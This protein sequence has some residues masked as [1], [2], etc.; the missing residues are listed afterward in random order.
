MAARIALLALILGAGIPPGTAAEWTVRTGE[1]IAAAI[2]QAAPG[3]TVVVERGR[4]EERLLIDKPLRL[5]G[6]G[7]PVLS[8]GNVGDT[9]RIKA[10]DVSIEGF[11]VRDSGADLTA[12]NACI[13]VE[14]GS[15]RVVVRGNDLAHCLFGLWLQGVREP[16]VQ[17]NLITGKR[18]LA[19]PLRGNG[20]QLYA[21]EFALIENNNISFTRDGVY[22]DVSH[23]AVFRGNRMH[24]LRY[25]THY[26]NSNGNL[27]ENNESFLNRGGLAMMEVRDQVVRG[28]RAWGNSDHGIMLRSIVDSLV[29]GNIVAANQRGLFIFNAEYNDIRNNLVIDN[30]VGAHVWA[31]S[32]NNLVEGNDFIANRQQ[33]RYVATRDERWGVERGNFWSNYAGW[34]RDGDG[35]GDVPYEASD[36]VDRL[37]WRHP[38]VKLLLASPAIQALRLAGQQFPLLRAPSIVDPNPR[39]QPHFADWSQWIGRQHR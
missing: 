36:V 29:E 7:R 26:M 32:V 14:P 17:G 6:R 16:R 38:I 12:Q 34:D 3:D 5:L 24:R 15:D 31:G 10:A 13:Y 8:A 35:I 22:V 21:T 20:I 2:G 23:R 33:V 11:I 25:G 19:S 1:P 30:H 9:I 28:N 37:I 18:E 4:Y 27:W 39:R